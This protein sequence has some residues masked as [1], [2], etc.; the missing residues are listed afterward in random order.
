MSYKKLL[1]YYARNILCDD[2]LAED[3]VHNAFI[4]ILNNIDKIDET[5]SIKTKAY[6]VAIVKRVSY[7]LY[8]KNKMENV[9]N[10]DDLSTVA[11]KSLINDI[12][13]FNGPLLA[14][15]KLPPVDQDIFILKYTYGFSNVEIANALDISEGALYKR[16][17]RGKM[18][19]KEI[20]RSEEDLDIWMIKN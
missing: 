1:F 3:A 6:L 20:L 11:E 19:L 9:I 13:L 10:I 2:R 4:R 15:K 14:I 17:Q 7:D 16:L 5:N 18:K 12:D 8:N